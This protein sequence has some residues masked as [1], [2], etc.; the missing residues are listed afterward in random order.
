[1]ASKANGHANGVDFALCVKGCPVSQTRVP[2]TDL[3]DYIDRP[4]VARANLAVTTEVPHGSKE[5]AAKYKDYTVLQ[6]H[7]LF[8]D[9]DGDG[10]IYPWDTYVGFRELGFNV[11][12]CILAVLIINLSF[13]YPTRLAHSYLPDPFFRVYVDSIHKAK[14]GSD[15]GVYDTEGRFIPQLFE[16]LFSKWDK[17]GDGALRLSELASMIKGHRCAADPYGW[18]ANFFEWGTTW[19]LLQKDGKLYKEDLRQL[20]DGSLFWRIRDERKTAKGW[21]R[22]FGL[23]GDWFVGGKKL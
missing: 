2:A 21:D 9:R 7:V 8:W 16:N 18:G 6:Q 12:F 13:S 10:C 22:G 20:Y 17:D 14:H 3:Y 4:G 15:S 5:H 23:G 1:M 19:L 11:I